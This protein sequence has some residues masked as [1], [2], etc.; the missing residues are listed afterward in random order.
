MSLKCTETSLSGVLVIESKVFSDERGAVLQS[1]RQDEYGEV[2]I[3]GPFVQ[4]NVSQSWGG[5]SGDCTT[6][7]KIRKANSYMLRR[8][9]YLT[10]WWTYAWVR[11]LSANG[12]GFVFL[13]DKE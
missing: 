6:N 2:G 9:R 8:G 1:Y 3:E 7:W 4:D 12:R 10:W 5:A 11:V 13:G